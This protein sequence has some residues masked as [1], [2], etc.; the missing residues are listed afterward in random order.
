MTAA[1]RNESELLFEEYLSAQGYTD[2]SRKK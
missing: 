2:W 1:N